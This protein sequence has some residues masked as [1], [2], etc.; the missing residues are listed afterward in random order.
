MFTLYI[1]LGIVYQVLLLT[2]YF[3]SKKSTRKTVVHH[4]EGVSI[5][6]PIRNE[7]VYLERCLTSIAK[8]NYPSFEVLCIDD[9]STDDSQAIAHACKEKFPHISIRIFNSPGQGKK[10]AVSY[11]VSQSAYEL[12]LTTDA[13][14]IFPEDWIQNML[15]AL[16]SEVQL[17]AGPVMSHDKDGFFGGF[18]QLD[19]ASIALV[20]KASIHMQQPLMCSAANMLYRK[21]AFETVEGFRGNEQI[22]SGDDEFLLKKIVLHYGAEAVN[23]QGDSKALVYTEPMPTWSDLFQQ[24]IRWASKW[25]AHGWNIHALASLIPV[26]LQALFL[27]LFFLPFL[28]PDLWGLACL[29]LLLKVLVERFVLGQVLKSYGINHSIVLWLGTSLVH[30]AYVLATGF[31]TFFRKI[32]WKGRKSLR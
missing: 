24:R 8:L 9:H 31:Q 5:I 18:Q 25:K 26:V 17:V 2:L 30:P 16:G 15:A 10:A 13:D 4:Q 27:F 6:L 19:W 28:R 14:C 7:T 29:L 22:L 1:S 23:Y 3:V 21:S 12:I 11:G 32:E 20:T